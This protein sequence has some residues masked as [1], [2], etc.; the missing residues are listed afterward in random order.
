MEDKTTI[1]CARSSLARNSIFNT[2]FITRAGK[3]ESICHCLKQM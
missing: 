3:R 1:F 2:N